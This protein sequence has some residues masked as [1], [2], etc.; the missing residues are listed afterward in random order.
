MSEITVNKVRSL[1]V[2]EADTRKIAA[3]IKSITKLDTAIVHAAKSAKHL[4]SQLKNVR[5]TLNDVQKELRQTERA[6]N[7]LEKSFRKELNLKVSTRERQSGGNG[8]SSGVRDSAGGGGSRRGISSRMRGGPS[9]GGLGSSLGG[10][11]IGGAVIGGIAAIGSGLASATRSAIEFESKMAEVRKV[12]DGLDDQKK[13]EEMG[14]QIRDLSARLPI[15]AEGIADIVAAGGQAGIAKDELVKF[16]EQAAKVGIAFDISAEQAGEALAKTKTSLGLTLDETN[17]LLGSINH[18]SNGMASTGAEVLQVVKGVG[19]LGEQA[20]V[21]AQHTAALGSAMIAAG[22]NAS[23]ATTSTKNLFL[24]LGQG[25]SATPK[26]EKAFKRLGLS[27][28]KVAKDM[29][30]DSEKTIKDVFQRIQMLAPE[31]RAPVITQ[32]FGKLS[33]GTIGPLVSNLDLLNK[34]FSLANDKAAAA[35]SIQKEFESRSKTTAN[36]IQLLKNRFENAKIELGNKLLPIFQKFL[37]VLDNP[38]LQKV[39]NVLFDGLIQGIETISSEMPNVDGLMQNFSLALETA[40]G[41]FKTAWDLAKPLLGALFDLSAEIGPEII[42]VFKEIGSATEELGA[43]FTSLFSSTRDGSEGLGSIVLK[44][45]KGT[46]RF[47]LDETRKI[48]E[49]L[50]DSFIGLRQSIEAFKNGN[51]FEGLKKLG[52][53]LVDAVLEPLRSIVRQIIK[54]ADAVPGMEGFASDSLREFAGVG[55]TKIE[56]GTIGGLGNKDGVSNAIN[57]RLGGFLGKTLTEAGSTAAF[58]KG[59][60]DTGPVGPDA[61]MPDQGPKMEGGIVTSDPSKNPWKGGGGGSGKSTQEQKKELDAFAELVESKIE[62]RVKAAQLRAGAAGGDAIA[63]GQLARLE[64]ERFA[65]ERRFAALGIDPLSLLGPQAGMGVGADSKPPVSVT[66]IQVQAGAIRELNISG[67]F[68]GSPDAVGKAL[69]NVVID[70]ISQAAQ[71][72]ATPQVG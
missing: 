47:T 56:K 67:N 5:G 7:K 43:V 34:A 57:K 51:L 52:T 9:M 23:N 55:R 1:L 36:T 13:F 62:E 26:T 17:N 49:F 18:L 22:A 15:A 70:Q 48:V 38:A 12:V 45:F 28:K 60:A 21:A 6:K 30:V 10:F 54:M 59:L 19:A 3:A 42:T 64:G 58:W 72:R 25:D 37:K 65:K 68:Q 50:K 53:I 31:K 20:G 4:N 11:G 66:I 63:A 29:Q 46:I 71:L 44:V 61:W 39:V 69:M 41:L 8:R 14:Q 24:A 40:G 32:I 35:S 33:A 2:V 27:A 16:A